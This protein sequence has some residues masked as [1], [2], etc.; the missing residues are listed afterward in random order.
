MSR[1]IRTQ[2]AKAGRMVA[3]SVRLTQ[4]DNCWTEWYA[5]QG[6]APVQPARLP[7]HRADI[8]DPINNF[9]VCRKW[10]QD[11]EINFRSEGCNGSQ[12]FPAISSPLFKSKLIFHWIR[13]WTNPIAE[14]AQSKGILCTAGSHANSK[15]TSQWI[16]T[17]SQSEHQCGFTFGAC[18]SRKRG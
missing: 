15:Q 3:Q 13:F 12:R 8:P 7:R 4:S 16:Q 5:W 1:V 9:R 14:T 18:I 6:H 10:N 11:I 2:R 17:V